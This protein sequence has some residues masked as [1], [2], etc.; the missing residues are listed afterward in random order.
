MLARAKVILISDC[1]DDTVRA[2]RMIPAHDVAEALA[3]AERL[4][5]DPEASVAVI[6][7]GVSVIV[8]PSGR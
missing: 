2:M 6:P 3:L 8:E 4:L 7:D 5:G 1:P